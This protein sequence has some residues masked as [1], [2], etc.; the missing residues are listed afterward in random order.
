M[1]RL[2]VQSELSQTVCGEFLALLRIL[3]VGEC[4]YRGIKSVY[5]QWR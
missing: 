5:F 3:C 2:T 1:F 4:A